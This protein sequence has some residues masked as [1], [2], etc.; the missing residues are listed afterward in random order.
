MSYASRSDLEQAFT[1][2]EVRNLEAPGRDI[3]AALTAADA[4]IDSRLAVRYVVPITG[5]VPADVSRRL[6]QA[7]CNIARYQLYSDAATEDVT[8]RYASEIAWLRDVAA[9][10][11]LLPGVPLKAADGANVPGQSPA[12]SGQGK[13]GLDWCAYG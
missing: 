11:A 2:V 5:A 7:A 13:S 10:K 6:T 3:V 12:R 8:A 4:E 9:G 1:A